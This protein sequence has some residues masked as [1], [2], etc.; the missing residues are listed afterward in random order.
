MTLGDELELEQ[1]TLLSTS[2]M[3]P[4][5]VLIRGKISVQFKAVAL[6]LK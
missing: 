6:V 5:L 1:K 4:L 2:T 3:L